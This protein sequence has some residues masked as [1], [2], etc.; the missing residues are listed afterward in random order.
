[1]T[2]QQRPPKIS[3][4]NEALKQTEQWVK[5][6]HL[7][8]RTSY[9][10]T[11]QALLGEDGDIVMAGGNGILLGHGELS[12]FWGVTHDVG[13][14][15]GKVSV[16]QFDQLS[17][18]PNHP[19]ITRILYCPRRFAD[20]IAVTLGWRFTDSKV[21]YEGLQKPNDFVF[22]INKVTR[23]GILFPC[24][25]EFLNSKAH[26][27]ALKLHFITDSEHK[28]EVDW[29][30]D[31]GYEKI[32]HQNVN[33]KRGLF[34]HRNGQLITQYPEV[35]DPIP[36]LQSFARHKAKLPLIET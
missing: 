35:F 16:L 4:V 12:Y 27:Q 29:D 1:M 34:M 18:E 10:L 36:H 14:N 3:E 33:Y 15:F 26:T 13:S 17:S 28:R 2:E 24:P 11:D 21:L 9:K 25:D 22:E 5:A 6:W 30:A 31:L 8:L 23:P 20:L 7:K 32:V 19:I